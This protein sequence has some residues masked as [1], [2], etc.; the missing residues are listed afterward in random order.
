MAGGATS[1]T[2]SMSRAAMVR[3]S[4]THSFLICART[5]PLASSQLAPVTTIPA[6]PGGAVTRHFTSRRAG[7]LPGCGLP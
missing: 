7:S 3:L 4:F 1:W 6:M 5:S 2:C